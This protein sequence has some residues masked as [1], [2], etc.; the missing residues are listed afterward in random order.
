MF[1]LLFLPG[2]EDSTG[3]ITTLWQGTLSPVPPSQV[4]GETAAVTQF[5]RTE[6]SIEIRRAEPDVVYSWS[7]EEG[8][9][10]SDGVIQ[11]GP[12]LYPPLTPSEAGQAFSIAVFPSLFKS[13]SQLSVKVFSTEGASERLASWGKL[14]ER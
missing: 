14:S 5:G 7:V 10:Q 4:S 3:P 1:L 12:T 9:C 8:E 11:G 13:G 2:C 6:V